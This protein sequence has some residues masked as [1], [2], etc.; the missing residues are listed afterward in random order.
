MNP[1][2]RLSF[3]PLEAGDA[4]FVLELLTDADFLRFI[5]DRGVRDLETAAGYAEKMRLGV[6]TTGFG[7][8]GVVHQGR[9]VGLAGLI[10]REWLSHVDVGYALLPSAR[11]K[12]FAAEAVEACLQTAREMGLRE[13]LAI[14]THANQKSIDVLERAGFVDHGE[15]TVPGETQPI[16][17]LERSL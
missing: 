17:C 13:V 2:A 12:G 7:M 6:E 3:R 5:G 1:T 8:L 14:V 11:G 9:L 15:V 4:A 16:R 10:R